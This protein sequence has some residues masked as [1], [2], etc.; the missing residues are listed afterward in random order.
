[1]GPFLQLQ[2]VSPLS[3]L[4]GAWWQAGMPSG[5]G[6]AP[7]LSPGPQAKERDIR[8]TWIEIMKP[9]NPPLEDTLSLTTR[10]HQFQKNHTS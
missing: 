1:M 10:S 3:L 8:W 7:N 6:I 4:C 5:G 9:Q 2:R